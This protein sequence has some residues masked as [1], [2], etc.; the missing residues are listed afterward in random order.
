MQSSAR[1]GARWLVCRL[2]AAGWLAAAA[3]RA[4]DVAATFDP[5]LPAGAHCTVDARRLRPTQVAVGFKE[6]ELRLAKYRALSPKKQDRYLRERPL[7][8]VIGPGGEPYILDHHHLARLALQAIAPPLLYAEIRE[9]WRTLAPA[10]FW[11]RMQARHWVYLFDEQGRGPLSPSELPARIDAMR[12]DPYRSLAWAVRQRG[13]YAE[14]DAPY[15]D[16]QW[17]NFFRTRIA[18]DDVK[19]RFTDATDRALALARSEEARALPGFGGQARPAP[20]EP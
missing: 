6:V 9:N 15:A 20:E 14:S 19:T 1:V 4:A 16:F 10:E 18:L 5:A 13:G 2:L 3:A 17:A 11:E 7:P 12:D 8:L